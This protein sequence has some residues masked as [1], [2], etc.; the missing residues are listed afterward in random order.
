MKP[1][2]FALLLFAPLS[3]LA[4]AHAASPE[5]TYFAA[6]D[7]FAAKFTALG[8]AGNIDEEMV[9]DHQRARDELGKL[10]RPIVGPVAIRGFLPEGRTNLDSLFKGDEGFGLLDGMLYSSAD[11]KTHVV[12]TTDALLAHWLVEH[13]D[14]WGPKVANVPQEV[15]AALRSEAF[16]TQALLTDAAITKYVEIAVARP[17]GAAFAFAM[18][19]ARAQILGPRTPDE[20]IVSGPG[21][22]LVCGERTG[23]G[24]G[25]PDVGVREALAGGEAQVGSGA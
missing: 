16:Y 13:K 11:D 25:S 4:A 21:R 7:A 2:L 5:E 15:A 1:L 12:V 20:L 9:E 6:R 10:L 17:A 18:L 3:P 14:W 24:E 19:V 22:A 23:E 8:E